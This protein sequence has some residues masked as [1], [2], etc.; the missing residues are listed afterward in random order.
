MNRCCLLLLGLAGVTALGCQS[1]SRLLGTKDVTTY[2]TPALRADAARAVAAQ[3]TGADTPDQQELVNGLARKIQTESD[4]LVREAIVG[5]LASFPLP[6]A[7]QVL[8]AGLQDDDAGVRQASCRA[9]G[10]R[11]SPSVVPALARVAEHDEDFDTRVA[12]ATA[13][14]QIA[15][16]ESIK[17]LAVALE[18]KNPAMQYAGVQAMQAATGRDLGG[19]VEAYA[20][21]ARGDASPPTAVATRPPPAAEQADGSERGG[22]FRRLSPF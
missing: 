10:V 11:R 17:S 1:G 6:L 18:D 2:Q 15:S 22:F 3:A 12:A 5:A 7:E 13:L 8:A 20:A 9:L 21:L 16:P 4:P 19:D 14:G